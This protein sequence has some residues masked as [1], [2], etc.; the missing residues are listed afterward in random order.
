[1]AE[2][3]LKDGETTISCDQALRIART[4]AESAYRDL[5]TPTVQKENVGWVSRP[6]HWSAK[7]WLMQ[8]PQNSR[9]VKSEDSSR[10]TTIQRERRAWRPVLPK[11]CAT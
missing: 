3:V 7:P 1:M 10:R 2:T 4:D 6:V 5:S 9:N 11:F 8:S